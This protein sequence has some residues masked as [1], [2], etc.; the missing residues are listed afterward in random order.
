MTERIFYTDVCCH[1]FQAT[2]LDCQPR[3]KKGYEVIL[4]KT[5]FYPEGGGQPGDRGTLGGVHVTDTQERGEDILHLTDAPL[6]VGTQVTGTLDWNW[7][8]SLMQ[9]HSGEHIVSGILHR[10]TG[11][12]NV[13][14]HMGNDAIII[15]FDVELP[16]ELLQEVEQEAN[17]V[18]WKNLPVQVTYPTPEELETLDYRSKKALTGQVRIVTFP[19][20]DTCA[21][22]GTH[23]VR[24]GEI[25][26]IKILSVQKFK[27]GSRVEMLCGSRALTY[28]RDVFE[29][30]HRISV[31]LSAK[32]L[33]TADAV[34]RLKADKEQTDYR[35]N[36]LEQTL[37]QQKAEALAGVGD[38]LLFE[39][40]MAPGQ[41]SEAVGGG[42]GD[43][44]RTLRGVLRR[45]RERV[46]ICC[47]SGGGR[48]AGVGQDPEPGP[49][50]PRG[51][52]G[53]FR[54]GQR[55]GKASGNPGFLGQSGRITEQHP[56]GRE[57]TPHGRQRTDPADR[58]GQ[59]CDLSK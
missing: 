25:G 41:R 23:V 3:K 33:K 48:P 54:P 20:T 10:R 32:P 36:G 58:Y 35:L 7:R 53:Q 19:Q 12:N 50:R 46:Q 38:V 40:P 2:V 44:R 8:F 51:R 17:E 59:P 43:L 29:Q 56:A 31:A 22:C 13:G 37:F 9:N 16:P 52:Q 45:R 34:E 11:A 49:P 28:L 24:T 42:H 18:V 15:D 30:N 21:C 57:G 1:T 14:F 27:E 5:A 55:P 6:E 39:K 4:D 26:V 47:R